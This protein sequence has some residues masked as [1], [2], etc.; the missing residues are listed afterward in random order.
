M[1][2]SDI[3]VRYEACE[4][5]EHEPLR[6]FARVPRAKIR[7]FQQASDDPTFSDEDI[8]KILATRPAE[9]HLCQ[10]HASWTGISCLETLPIELQER[11]PDFKETDGMEL[12]AIK[13]KVA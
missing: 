5:E 8:A 2:T 3:Y 12:W 7:E 9:N 13:Q 4:I 10:L 1:H 6:L 11:E